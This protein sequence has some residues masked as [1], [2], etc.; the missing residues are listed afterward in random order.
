MIDIKVLR[1]KVY[2][3]ECYY[4]TELDAT[5]VEIV[6]YHPGAYEREALAEAENKPI[7]MQRLVAEC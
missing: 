6:H 5:I 7:V 2:E 1:G 3:V 4:D